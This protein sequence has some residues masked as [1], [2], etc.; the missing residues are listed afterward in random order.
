MGNAY[1]RQVTLKILQTINVK[2]VQQDVWNARFQQML[3]YVQTAMQVDIGLYSMEHVYVQVQVI[4]MMQAPILA[5]HAIIVAKLAVQDFQ[6]INVFLATQITE[7][8]IHQ[9]QNVTVLHI[10]LMI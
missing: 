9:L 2:V 8:L 4:F 6:P 1:V 10:H 7:A 5:L 3:R